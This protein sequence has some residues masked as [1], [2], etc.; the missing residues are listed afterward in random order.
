[1][2]IERWA[3]SEPCQRSSLEGFGKI[4]IAF[5]Y[6]CK[7]LDLKSLKGSEYV[8]GFKYVRIL[9]IPGM[10]I[11]QGSKFPGL[12]RVWLFSEIWQGSE[13]ALGCNYERV[14]SIAGFQIWQVSAYAKVTEGSEYARIW[15]NKVWVNCYY[16]GMDLSMHG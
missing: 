5:N 2:L 6:F 13:Y 12:H 3:Y 9:N 10:S 14:L 7:T 16:Y 15:L 11:C 1:M 8:S 4:I